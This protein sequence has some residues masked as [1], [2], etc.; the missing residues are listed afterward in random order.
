MEA[1]TPQKCD[2]QGVARAAMQ[3]DGLAGEVARKR[4][5]MAVD[6]VTVVIPIQAWYGPLGLH[7]FVHL[8]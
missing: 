6:D 2:V 4:F 5:T 8:R 7:V 3:A 1:E